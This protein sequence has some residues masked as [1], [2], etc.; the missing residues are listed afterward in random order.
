MLLFEQGFAYSNLYF[1]IRFEGKQL[2]IVLNFFNYSMILSLLS[3]LLQCLILLQHS[4]F[5]KTFNFDLY[6]LQ[7]VLLLVF[8]QIFPLDRFIYLSYDSFEQMNAFF[9]L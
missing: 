7:V 5:M 1:E 4:N 9:Y 8:A 6:C 2:P 3:H